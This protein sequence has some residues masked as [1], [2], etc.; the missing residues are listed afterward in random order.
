MNSYFFDTYSFFEVLKGN[1]SYAKYNDSAI[2][3]TI[4]HLAEL[5]FCLK[6]RAEPAF[7]DRLVDSYRSC[8][9][10]VTLEDVKSAMGFKLNHKNM[11]IPDA[12]GY[13]V[14]KR[15]GVLLVTGDDHFKGLG[16]VEFVK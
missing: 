9:I 2:A 7:A 4:F 1:P 10:E 14:A 13:V 6:K 8:L 15:L 12:I 5:N 16:N 11:S 3:T